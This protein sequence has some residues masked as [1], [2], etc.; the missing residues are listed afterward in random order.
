MTGKS[1]ACKRGMYKFCNDVYFFLYAGASNE[2]VCGNEFDKTFTLGTGW[3]LPNPDDVRLQHLTLEQEADVLYKEL[4]ECGHWNATNHVSN[5]FWGYREHI[6]V[7]LSDVQ[8]RLGKPVTAINE[9]KFCNESLIH[10]RRRV[11]K[12]FSPVPSVSTAESRSNYF[13]SKLK[14][15]PENTVVCDL[16]DIIA[17]HGDENVATQQ[18][19][20]L[21]SVMET[22]IS[23]INAASVDSLLLIGYPLYT[24]ISVACFIA[25]VNMFDK[26]GLVKPQNRYGHAIVFKG[27]KRHSGWFRTLATAKNLL[28]P[29]E[30]AGLSL[31]SWISIKKLLN[32]KVYADIVAVNNLCIVNETKPILSSVLGYNS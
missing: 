16:T 4:K 9:T 7:K 24:Q 10:F 3:S 13:Q 15:R 2:Y 28:M 29:E 20:C 6:T 14:L 26:Y 1:F 18:Y 17:K 21:E 27:F 32:Q 19:R 31:I 30:N 11:L 25:V 22:V 12:K 5:V 23:I 8:Y